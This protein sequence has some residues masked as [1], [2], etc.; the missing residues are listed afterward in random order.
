MAEKLEKIIG[1]LF[2]V[3]SRKS[4]VK[5]GGAGFVPAAASRQTL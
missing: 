5:G 4:S 1:N 2:K 3:E